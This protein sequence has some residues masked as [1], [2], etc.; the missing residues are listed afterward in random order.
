MESLYAQH[1]SQLK[2]PVSHLI[3]YLMH[4][5]SQLNIILFLAA[6]EIKFVPLQRAKVQPAFM[7]IVILKHLKKI[8]RKFSQD[9]FINLYIPL[10]SQEPFQLFY[11]ALRHDFPQIKTSLHCAYYY[12]KHQSTLCQPV[13][14]VFRLRDRQF[15]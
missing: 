7:A 2:L 3:K 12:C 13:F 1:V 9:F 14:R 15:P 5:N 6:Q 4:K 8:L 11:F 10:P